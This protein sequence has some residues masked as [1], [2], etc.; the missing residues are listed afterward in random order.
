M[1]APPH[2]VVVGPTAAGKTALSIQLAVEAGAE[3]VSADALMVYRGADVGTAKPTAEERRGVPHHAIDL[4][5]PSEEA[6]LAAW[7]A[8]ARAAV[9]SCEFRGV[10]AVVVGGTGLY[11]HALVD[12]F[13]LP[14]TYPEVRAELEASADP[15][16]VLHTRLA[17]LDPVAAGRMEPGNRRRVVRALE[18]CLGSGRPFSSFGPGVGAFPATDRFRLVGLAPDPVRLGARIERRVAEQV[19][20][21]LVEE[22]ARL[23]AIPGGLSRTC[24]QG[25]GYKE[26][27]LHLEQGL[28]LQEALA[29]D[30]ANTRRFARRQRSWFRRDPRIRWLD[31]G[32]DPLAQA[33]AA[34]A[35][36]RR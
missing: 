14:G 32:E 16:P 23:L 27:L 20:A 8:A 7:L 17:A 29:L 25:L 3:V 26:V 24:R 28:P 1:A 36:W 34:R 11:V 22:T 2:L 10:P 30:V 15:A 12:D 9:A 18:V 13:E 4:A 21:G 35:L 31:V 33:P 6:D 19:A 5:E